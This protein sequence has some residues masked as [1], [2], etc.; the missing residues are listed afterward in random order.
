MVALLLVVGGRPLAGI[1]PRY[2]LLTLSFQNISI[3]DV[4]HR[5]SNITG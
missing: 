5:L 4:I 1:A 2:K 3:V